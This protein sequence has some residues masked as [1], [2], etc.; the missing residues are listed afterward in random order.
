M[1]IIGK[2]NIPFHAFRPVN[3]TIGAIVLSLS[4]YYLAQE[5]FPQASHNTGFSYIITLITAILIMA[6]GYI[7]NDAL[8]VGADLKNKPEKVY[9]SSYNFRKYKILSFS[10]ISSSLSICLVFTLMDVFPLDLLIAQAAFAVILLA[11]NHYLKTVVLLGNFIIALLGAWA[12]LLPALCFIDMNDLLDTYTSVAQKMNPLLIFSG[13][14]AMTMFTR[15]LMKDEEDVQGDKHARYG[16]FAVRLPR[17]VKTVFYGCCFLL[18]VLGPFWFSLF[19]SEVVF[20]LT[21]ALITLPAMC[22]AAFAFFP[23][24]EPKYATSA[25]LLKLLMVNALILFYLLLL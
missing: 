19:R 22:C 2:I 18:L 5:V 16:T 7:Q 1:P 8:D 15:E 20:E 24:K 13:F 10:I 21:L 23:H 4:Y 17:G 25:F 12:F 14:S 6:G 9:I 11:Y 3:L